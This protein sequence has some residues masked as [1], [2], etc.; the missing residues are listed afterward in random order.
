M[1]QHDFAVLYYAVGASAAVSA[2][3]F[4]GLTRAQIDLWLRA[5]RSEMPKYWR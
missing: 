5:A 2:A 3:L 1:N 4:F